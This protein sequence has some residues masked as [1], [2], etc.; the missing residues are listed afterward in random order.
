[1]RETRQLRIAGRLLVLAVTGLLAMLIVPT[2]A[3]APANQA[4]RIVAGPTFTEAADGGN[5]GCA[6]SL[7]FTTAAAE[8]PFEHG[9]MLWLQE[10][11]SVTVLHADGTYEGHNDQFSAGEIE[12]LGLVPP[13][14]ELLE[15]RQGFGEIW[16]KIGGPAAALGWATAPESSYVATVQYFERGAMIQR[17]QLGMYALSIFNHTRGQWT[18]S[19]QSPAGL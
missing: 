9:T 7:P 11:G 14:P 13:A 3:A 12:V 17:G 18:G 15:P 2:V 6:A 5:L 1:M 10:W 16:R 19:T 8:Q 4:C